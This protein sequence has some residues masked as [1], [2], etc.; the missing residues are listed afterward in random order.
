MAGW[1]NI[2]KS[3]SGDCSRWLLSDNEF[4]H[5]RAVEALNRTMKDTDNDQNIMGG[6]GVLMA[7]EFRQI[8]PVITKRTPPDDTNACLKVTTLWKHVKKLLS[9]RL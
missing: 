7:G 1:S 8:L 4:S 3:A 5:K 6:I 9:L 2:Q